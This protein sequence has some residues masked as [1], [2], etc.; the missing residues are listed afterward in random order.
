MSGF[1]PLKVQ[2]VQHDTSSS[3]IVTLE[4]DDNQ[5]DRFEFLA[6]QYL[7]FRHQHNGEEIRR[8]YSICSPQGA[9]SLQVG[10]RQVDE[11][12]FSTFANSSLNVGDILETMPPQ[13][14]FTLADL[15][16]G[17]RVLLVAAG[18]GITPMMSHIETLLANDPKA[19]VTLIY[20]NR[21]PNTIM[22]RERLED[23]KSEYMT[24]F[25]LLHV[26]SG[27]GQEADLFTGR[28]DGQ[29]VTSIVD[30]WLHQ[31]EFDAALI[32]GPQEMIMNV[33]ATLEQSMP[34]TKVGYELFDTGGSRKA[35]KAK[36]SNTLKDVD[37]TVI[38]DGTA[39]KIAMAN[40]D[41][42]LDVARENH[43]DAPYSCRGGICSTCR[44]KIIKGTGEM[45]VNHALEDY[46][47]EAGYALSCQ[48]RPTSKTL[49]I[50][51]DEGH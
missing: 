1:H 3:V 44:C 39:H 18:S 13:G 21:T 34:G 40:D 7:T 28:I 49:V 11:G 20:G 23:L 51:Y 48:L 12:I 41:H 50:S 32:C 37:L 31:P 25:T 15:P 27:A 10:V 46:E 36:T 22:F 16:E 33:K 24:R 17:A 38:I 19:S 4:I 9:G 8:N 2:Q 47:V 14:K 5:K 42:V 35:P 45:E 6:G 30:E 26:L 43:I 29:R